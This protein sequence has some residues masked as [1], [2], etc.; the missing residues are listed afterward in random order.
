[1][2][3]QKRIAS[4]SKPVIHTGPYN[5]YND[6]EQW[7]RLSSGCPN[8][9][10]FCYE[11]EEPALY[12]CPQIVR[13]QVKIMDMNFLAYRGRPITFE[14]LRRQRVGGKVV[15]YELVC[16]IDWRYLTL[17]IGRSLKRSRFINIRLAWDFGFNNQTKI[18]RALQMLEKAGYASR[19]ITIF[20]ICNWKI[21]Y[22]ENCEKLDLCKVWRVK[23]AD[24][25]FDNQ[26]SPL[27]APINWTDREIKR[28]R[29]K[30]RRHNHLVR[31]L[32]NP[33]IK[34]QGAE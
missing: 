18:K 2:E 12:D 19:D 25:Y 22:S 26:L 20:I 8:N 27:I 30:V 21:P 16:G 33:D 11:P 32:G 4:K 3:I 9:C 31:Y 10:P 5:K 23:V 15:Y 1:M 13:N 14:F 6:S 7:V 28:F 29:A 34:E 24:C 17:E